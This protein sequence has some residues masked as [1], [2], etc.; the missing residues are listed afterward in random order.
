[1]KCQPPRNGISTNCG[2]A[3]LHHSVCLL[4]FLRFCCRESEKPYQ[5]MRLIIHSQSIKI[6]PQLTSDSLFSFANQSLQIYKYSWAYVG[7]LRCCNICVSVEISCWGYRKLILAAQY[8]W[9]PATPIIATKTQTEVSSCTIKAR[10][11]KSWSS[12]GQHLAMHHFIKQRSLALSACNS[13]LS[14]TAFWI[15]LSA[16]WD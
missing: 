8:A 6:T 9:H 12:W 2:F 3:L 11:L 10:P 14:S 15:T 7:K 16:E 13:P 5:G 4:L 1:M